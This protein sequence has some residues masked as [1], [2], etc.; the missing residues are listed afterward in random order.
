MAMG[1]LC[2]VEF[3]QS[4]HLSVLLHCHSIY[5]WELLRLRSPMPRGPFMAGV[6]VDDLVLLERVVSGLRE[7][8]VALQRTYASDQGQVCGGWLAYKR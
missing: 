3:A 2:A 5:P 7:Q 1:D 4:S 8:C 6:V